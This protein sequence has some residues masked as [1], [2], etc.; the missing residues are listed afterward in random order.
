MVDFVYTALSVS[1]HACRQL[2]HGVLRLLRRDTVSSAGLYLCLR[3]VLRSGAS[4]RFQW[5]PVSYVRCALPIV[6]RALL[7]IARIVPSLG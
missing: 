4:I 5:T 7:V 3:C 2:A 1:F 6:I